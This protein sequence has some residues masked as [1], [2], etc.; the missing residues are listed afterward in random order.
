MLS[1]L[2]DVLYL[3]LTDLPQKAPVCVSNKEFL[4]GIEV[5][6]HT[7]EKLLCYFSIILYERFVKT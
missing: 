3:C 1:L 4:A 2:T 5:L 7:R 6:N